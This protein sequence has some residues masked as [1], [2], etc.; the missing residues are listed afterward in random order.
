MDA[1]TFVREYAAEQ[2]RAIL[3]GLGKNSDSA[4]IFALS[5]LIKENSNGDS[6][7]GKRFL[8]VLTTRGEGFDRYTNSQVILALNLLGIGQSPEEE[9]ILL[10]RSYCSSD[11]DKFQCGEFY[12]LEKFGETDMSIDDGTAPHYMKIYLGLNGVPE[13]KKK[14]M[15]GN[16]R[17]IG[18][19]DFRE[20]FNDRKSFYKLL[21]SNA[22]REF[23]ILLE[24]EHNRLHTSINMNLS[25]I[26]GGETETDIFRITK[27]SA[28]KY[29]LDKNVEGFIK[30]GRELVE[31]ARSVKA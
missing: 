31:K 1:E 22:P 2:I 5:T 3:G 15:I 4:A 14:Q 28:E 7:L 6:I 19:V 20:L 23:D 9:L 18:L 12:L 29:K 11:K 24:P 13:I 30:M 26:G 17:V 21:I 16:Y 10:S 25:K 8:P 27:E